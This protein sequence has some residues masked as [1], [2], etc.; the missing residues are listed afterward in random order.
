MDRTQI[1]EIGLIRS[2]TPA[3]GLRRPFTLT[4]DHLWLGAPVLVLLC[5][6]FM[7]Q[8]PLLDFW[9]H[10]KVGEIIATSHALPRIDEFSFTAAG[11]PFIVQNWLAEVMFYATYRVGGFP[12]IV[13]LTSILAAVG[14]VLVYRLCFQATAN[15]LVV[16]FLGFVLALSN[17]SFTRP[18]AFSFTLFAAFYFVLSNFR[19][20]RGDFLWILPILMGLW[21]NLHGAF[22]LGLG[23]LLLYMATE[24]ARRLGA[25]SYDDALTPRQL[26]KL[27]F[28]FL[29][30]LAAT[31]A[32][33]ESYRVYDYIR[34]VVSDPAS[35]QYVSEWQ[36]PRL[37]QPLSILFFYA[38]FFLGLLVF[39]YAKAKPD[40]TEAALFF[41]FGVFAMMSIR[42]CAW[43]TTA[44]Y[45]ILARYLPLVDFR[46]L[47]R[48]RRFRVVKRAIE[49][50]TA[51]AADR[52]S[53][54]RVNWAIASLALVF[55][56]GMSPWVRPAVSNVSLLNA[57]TPV[58]AA[59]YIEQQRITG[60]IYHPQIFGDYLI[61][62]L[63]PQQ[64]S[65]IDGRVHIF[66]V[67]F[68]RDT[69][70]LLHD[71]HW[72]QVLARWDI[73]YMLLQKGSNDQDTQSAIETARNSALWTKLYED[74]ISILFEKTR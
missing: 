49:A 23:I 63:W 4:I 28:V 53:S 12:L 70:F 36:P 68:V 54:Q 3:S 16:V 22:V 44:A 55:L 10:L 42:N 43:F 58:G 20:R 21:V 26:R 2:A 13:F 8:L 65:F 62:R 19:S 41:G 5:N 29:L 25:R 34:T 38:P 59:N 50:I 71:S 14:F 24:G 72:Q 1:S 64:R 9:W 32:N 56:V 60:R 67:N 69:T 30:C 7:F 74:D 47:Q 66:D 73:D 18:Q 27:V 61:W 57:Q 52:T 48:L 17:Y 15:R 51:T 11:H 31:L 40:L 33:P 45:P 39:T 6:S 37:N 46:P 35:Q